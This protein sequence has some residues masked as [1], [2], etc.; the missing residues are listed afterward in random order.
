MRAPE[1]ARLWRYHKP[2]GLLVSHR[3]DRGRPTVFDN[4]PPLKGARWIAIG[5][6]DINTTGLLLLTTD[7]EIANAL[8]APP[9][10]PVPAQT[11]NLSH[12]ASTP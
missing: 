8:S 4:L 9:P 1:P 3:D 2:R 11:D 10:T 5:R 6:L 7:G 12:P